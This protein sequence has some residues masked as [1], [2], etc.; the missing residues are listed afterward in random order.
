MKFIEKHN[1]ISDKQF[2]FRSALSTEDAMKILTSEIYKSL[3]QSKPAIAVL[4]D[5]ATVFDTVNRKQLLNLLEKIGFQGICLQLLES[6]IRIQ[7][8]K[9]NETLSE[10]YYN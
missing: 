9:L 8:V 2:G 4:L 3:D 1:L 7:H 5:L 10:P 6:H